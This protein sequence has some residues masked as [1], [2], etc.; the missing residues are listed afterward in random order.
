MDFVV[1]VKTNSESAKVVE[2]AECSLRDHSKNAKAASM[3]LIPFGEVW[4]DSSFAKFFS[5]R[6][7]VIR[8]I[9][10]NFIRM[11]LWMAG[12][13]ANGRNAVNQRKELSH[14]MSVCSRQLAGWASG[15]TVQCRPSSKVPTSLQAELL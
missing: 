11:I 3:F 2:P 6:L 13:P 15:R 4:F 14:V 12:L 5:V 1:A 10:I 7:G 8:S 9:S